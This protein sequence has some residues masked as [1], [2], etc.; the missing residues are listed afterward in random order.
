MEN[1]EG[2]KYYV[3]WDGERFMLIREDDSVNIHRYEC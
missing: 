1:G 3:D 2:K